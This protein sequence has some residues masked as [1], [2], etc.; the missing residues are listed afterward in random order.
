V[1]LKI[2]LVLGFIPFKGD[3]LHKLHCSYNIGT[4]Q[5]HEI[6]MPKLHL[7]DRVRESI[8]VRQYSKSTE[9]SYVAWIRRYI[10]FH[11]KIGT[12]PVYLVLE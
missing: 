3:I 5:I 9:K 4:M 2:C 7:L 1:F 6:A 10:L 8:R 11:K 12:R